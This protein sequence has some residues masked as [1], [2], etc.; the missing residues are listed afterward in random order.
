MLKCLQFDKRDKVKEL[1]I[2]RIQKKIGFWNKV[3]HWELTTGL[4]RRSMLSYLSSV[5]QL[6]KGI[7]AL[8]HMLSGVRAIVY[9]SDR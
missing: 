4:I 3:D 6:K 2:W 5:H 1:K 9:I 7:V 8:D